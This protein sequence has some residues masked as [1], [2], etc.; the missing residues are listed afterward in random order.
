VELVKSYEFIDYDDNDDNHDGDNNIILAIWSDKISL[1][2]DTQV[3]GGGPVGTRET[4]TGILLQ[5]LCVVTF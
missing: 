5:L 3:A 1:C 4:S 2:G